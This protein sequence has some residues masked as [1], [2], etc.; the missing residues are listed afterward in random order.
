LSEGFPPGP[1]L[2]S[3]LG[4]SDGLLLGSSD[5]LLLGWSDGLLLGWSDPPLG[6]PEA[7]LEPP[8]ERGRAEA[9]GAPVSRVR[10][11][12]ASVA[13]A[14][15]EESAAV[16]PDVGSGARW[17]GPGVSMNALP[18]EE[19]DGRGA[20]VTR[21]SARDSVFASAGDALLG[22]KPGAPSP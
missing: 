6:C 19:R 12:P 9:S 5:G 13:D 22:R 17:D 8:S 20:R 16:H 18:V 3:L 15:G 1:W 2:G 14:V 21:S 7:R 11:P 4:S 10:A